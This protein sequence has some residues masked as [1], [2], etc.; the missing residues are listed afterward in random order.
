MRLS[1]GDA[2]RSGSR[3]RGR[4][5]ARLRVVAAVVLMLLLPAGASSALLAPLQPGLFWGPLEAHVGLDLRQQW[6]SNVFRTSTPALGDFS[7]HWRPGLELGLSGLRWTLDHDVHY[8]QQYYWGLSD[9]ETRR[10]TTEAWQAAQRG[11]VQLLS[12]TEFR[13]GWL[14]KRTEDP[15][16]SDLT[17]D[18]EPRERRRREA[19]LA[20]GQTLGIGAVETGLVWNLVQDRYP[21][22][23]ALERSTQSLALEL[24]LRPRPDWILLGR[25][26]GSRS[27]RPVGAQLGLGTRLDTFRSEFA[28]SGMLGPLQTIELGLGA[29]LRA[30]DG[31]ARGAAPL[32]RVRWGWEPR[33]T[34][35]LNLGYQI[36]TQ[37]GVASDWLRTQRFEM[38]FDQRLRYEL[39]LHA[40]AWVWE[41]RFEGG[42]ARRDLNA[43]SRVE[44]SYAREREHW[45]ELAWG[46]D[47]LRRQSDE[48]LRSF[49]G[50]ALFLDLRLRY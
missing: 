31:H 40:K 14:W 42:Y 38:A 36:Q 44:M 23:P 3:S 5:V 29:D 21:E 49:A 22:D 41:T 39:G 27:E 18:R 46:Y 17:L 2:G 32:A 12:G 43:Q 37:D 25:F 4:A 50:H 1:C 33:R 47:Y 7:S 8:A 16:Y 35:R 6:E 48:P 24:R 13:G 30:A 20:L 34:T 15:L 9:P 11:E 26:T 45:F 19:E 28:A 10:Q